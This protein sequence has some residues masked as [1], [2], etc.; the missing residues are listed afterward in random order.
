MR[1]LLT[2]RGTD[3]ITL[4]VVRRDRGR[5]RGGSIFLGITHV[6]T[7]HIHIGYADL[8]MSH[9]LIF[10]KVGQ[11]EE[12]TRESPRNFINVCTFL[13]NAATAA[14]PRTIA[15]VKRLRINSS[16]YVNKFLHV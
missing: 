5:I 9:S 15:P 3:T 16:V 1:L 11:W 12:R 6:V 4:F 2:F 8:R 7:T 13:M 10:C 14:A